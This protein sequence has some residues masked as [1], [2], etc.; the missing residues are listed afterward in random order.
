MTTWTYRVRKKPIS[1]TEVG[2]GIVE[3]Y[4]STNGGDA[5]TRNDMAPVAVG[6]PGDPN[7]D[8]KALDELRWQLTEMLKALDKPILKDDRPIEE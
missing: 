5:W 1:T 7:A 3:V 8:A 4:S 6:E 2:Y